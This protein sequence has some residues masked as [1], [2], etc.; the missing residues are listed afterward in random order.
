MEKITFVS[1]LDI[2]DNYAN[3]TGSLISLGFAHTEDEELH[4]TV[5]Q[6]LLLVVDAINSHPSLSGVRVTANIGGAGLD[7]MND[8]LVTK[9]HFAVTSKNCIC[10][11]YI[12]ISFCIVT[13]ALSLRTDIYI[14]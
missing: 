14:G 10:Y 12:F 8:N 4:R 1:A 3:V 13:C 5:K 11:D 7:K 2:V 9:I 6:S